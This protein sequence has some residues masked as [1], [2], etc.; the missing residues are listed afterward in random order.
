MSGKGVVLKV[1]FQ[2]PGAAKSCKLS[3]NRSCLETGISR[4]RSRKAG[5]AVE[6]I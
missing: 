4:N 3:A 6:K 2:E 5:R 1:N